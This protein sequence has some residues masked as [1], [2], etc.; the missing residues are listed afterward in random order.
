VLLEAARRY[1]DVP[2]VITENGMAEAKDALRASQLIAHL[3]AIRAAMDAG[4]RVDGYLY[5][6]LFDNYEWGSFGPRFGLYRVDYANGFKRTLTEGGEAFQEV[7]RR[8]GK[9]RP[10][11]A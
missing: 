2:I 1:P 10:A 3:E 6:S 8:S 7:I 4:A 5:W 11:S 9:L